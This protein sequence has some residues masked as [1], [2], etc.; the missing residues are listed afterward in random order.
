MS[1]VIGSRVTDG[2]ISEPAASSMVSNVFPN[3]PH[4]KSYVERYLFF[5]IF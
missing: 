2:V 4:I 3:M 5:P 1:Y